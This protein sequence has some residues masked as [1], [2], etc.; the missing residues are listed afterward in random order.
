MPILKLCEACYIYRHEEDLVKEEETYRILQE[1]IRSDALFK[2][3]T[4]SSLK[5][6]NDPLYDNLNKDDKK[7]LLRLEMLE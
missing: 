3:L 5:G 6:E 4:G 2:A 1:A 7:K